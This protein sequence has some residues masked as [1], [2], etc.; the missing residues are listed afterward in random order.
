MGAESNAVLGFAPKLR[1]PKV[2]LL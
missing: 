1:S 2:G